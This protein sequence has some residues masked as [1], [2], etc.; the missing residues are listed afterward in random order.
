MKH[1]VGLCIDT[2]KG[3]L[4]VTQDKIY[5]VKSKTEQ[6]NK[7]KLTKDDFKIAIF[8]SQKHKKELK[9]NIRA[10]AEK[11]KAENLAR[12]TKK[13]HV[14][15]ACFDKETKKLVLSLVD[16]EIRVYTVKEN[17]KRI[18]LEDKPLSF[19]SKDIVTYMEITKFVVNDRQIL[20]LGTDVGTVEIYYLDEAA[21]KPVNPG[22][23]T[24]DF[25]RSY[26]RRDVKLKSTLMKR[27]QIEENRDLQVIKLRYARD[28]GLIVCALNDTMAKGVL[29]AFD[30]VDFKRTWG[31]ED[32]V[33][34]PNQDKYR[35]NIT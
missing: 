25:S 18:K 31:Y 3:K 35:I 14:S 1:N 28:V 30:A 12:Q 15:C 24:Y 16:C 17:G 26:K 6:E 29:S 11:K 34:G 7:P 32:S 22:R 13:I 4:D 8:D 19:K 23:I 5:Q 20:I 10:K 2:F 27:F 21:P 9:N 33:I